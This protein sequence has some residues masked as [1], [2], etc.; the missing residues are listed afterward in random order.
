MAHELG[1]P[2]ASL[3]ILLAVLGNDAGL[4]SYLKD[5]DTGI[6]GNLQVEVERLRAL[7]DNAEFV[8][9]TRRSSDADRRERVSL[10][11]LVAR[12]ANKRAVEAL[13]SSAKVRLSLPSM[14]RIPMEVYGNRRQLEH[15]VWELL[16]NVQKHAGPGASAFVRVR[17]RVDDAGR[18]AEC[19]VYDD[20]A[21]IPSEVRD[22]MFRESFTIGEAPMNKSKPGL[23]L[24]LYVVGRLIHAHGGAI[25]VRSSSR[26]GTAVTFRLPLIDAT[27]LG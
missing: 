6:L 3:R 17:F 14:A 25:R 15:V 2:V 26:F 18:F 5:R 23:G 1:S 13:G 19:T 12:T 7:V 9:A 8:L 20:G 22:R 4:R 27:E 11:E 24:G 10:V 16:S 21:G